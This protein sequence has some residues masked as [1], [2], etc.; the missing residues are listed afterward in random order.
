MQGTHAGSADRSGEVEA[1]L[2]PAVAIRGRP[3]APMALADRMEHY[4]V[5][6]VSVAVVDGGRI[7]WARGYGVAETG[8]ECAVDER[9]LFQAASISK[10][11]TALVALRLVERGLLDLD[12]DVN[13]RLRSWRLPESPLA[14]ERRVTLRRILSHT[15]GLTVSGVPGYAPG[16]PLPTLTQLLDGASPATNEPVRVE[17]E[18]GR[19]FQYSG[20]AYCL[21]EQLITD[22]TGRGFADFAREMVLEPLAMSDSTFARPMPAELKRRAAVGHTAAGDRMAGGWLV[23]SGV[24]AGGLWTTPSDLAR[25]VMELQRAYAGRS[26]LLGRAAARDMLT[27]QDASHVGLG[28]WMEGERTSARFYHTGSN[29]GYRARLVGYLQGGWGA[30]VMT[31]GENGELLCIEVLNAIASVYG[32]PDYI[33]EKE[34]ADVDRTGFASFAG[35][36]EVAGGYRLTVRHEDGR[37]FAS[38]PG[39]G[40][41]EMHPVSETSFFVEEVPAEITFTA[42]EESRPSVLVRLFGMDL[43]GKRA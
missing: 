28:P 5:P 42:G 13:W 29:L 7:V 43:R 23:Q 21:A 26:K 24:A 37:L 33:V 31:N 9:T 17:R 4:R 14:D 10:P 15:A 35:E 34:I 20:G 30:V 32:W 22:V 40:A 38:A 3:R 27:A 16:T 1:G 39:Y 25:F 11:V 36:Y 19:G 2:L 6:G 8:G 18:P 12:E 41:G